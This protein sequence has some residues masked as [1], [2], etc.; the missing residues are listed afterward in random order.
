MNA[1]EEHPA[2]NLRQIAA[3]SPAHACGG[4]AA[5][6]PNA[7]RFLTLPAI[8]QGRANEQILTAELECIAMQNRETSVNIGG[9]STMLLIP[10]AFDLTPIERL[11]SAEDLRKIALLAA[12]GGGQ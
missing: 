11:K 7:E 3:W 1:L 5:E 4:K 6:I 10:I 9:R 8:P 2:M 12:H